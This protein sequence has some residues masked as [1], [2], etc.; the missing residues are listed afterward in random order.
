MFYIDLSPRVRSIMTVWLAYDSPRP[1]VFS[2]MALQSGIF[3]NKSTKE[4]MAERKKLL[5]DHS[6][7]LEEFTKAKDEL[8]QFELA[9]KLEDK[10]TD[11]TK[12]NEMNAIIKFYASYFD[13]DSGNSREEGIKQLESFL[14]EETKTYCKRAQDLVQKCNTIAEEV[15]TRRKI[16]EEKLKREEEKIKIDEEK[17]T[18]EENKKSV[19]E[20][21]PVEENKNPVEEKK[22]VLENIINTFFPLISMYS[23]IVFRI[24]LSIFT[25]FISFKLIDLDLSYLIFYI[26]DIVIPT[27]VTSLLWFV[28]EYYRFYIKVLKYYKIAKTIYM[29]CKKKIYSFYIKIYSF[30]K[31]F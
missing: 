2:N 14:K 21:N 5:D 23:P 4:L 18:V 24:I 26:P 30:Y 15:I 3:D 11:K 6:D 28:W 10:L 22:P 19:E 12:N 25:I 1:H 17:K 8:K 7:R 13:E 27:V 20:K 29:F 31:K 9:K 16:F